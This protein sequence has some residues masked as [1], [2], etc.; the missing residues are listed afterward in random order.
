[1]KAKLYPLIVALFVVS[2]I[3]GLFMAIR[4]HDSNFEQMLEDISIQFNDPTVNSSLELVRQ[5]IDRSFPSD[6]FF[7][8]NLSPLT[9]YTPSSLHKNNLHQGQ[10]S[11]TGQAGSLQAGPDAPAIKTDRN[12]NGDPV[13]KLLG[14]PSWQSWLALPI[15]Y[16]AKVDPRLISELRGEVLPAH[17]G[18]TADES[19][20]APS[21]QRAL[22]KTR[23][24]VIL[25]EQVSLERE[26]AKQVYASSVEKRDAALDLLSAAARESQ[27]ALTSTLAERMNQGD[28]S[29]YH[30]FFI[31]N[32]MA[33]EGNLDTIIALSIRPDVQRIQASYPLVPLWTSGAPTRNSAQSNGAQTNTVQANSTQNT[34][35]S[36][37]VL[38]PGNW[39]IDLVNADEVW[40]RLG[41]RGEG[42][43]VAGFDTGVQYQHPAVE[44]NY[45]GRIGEDEYD[46][47]YN[48]FEPNGN[49]YPDGNLGA[50][51][52]EEPYD[53]DYYGTHGTHTM[54]TM[55][56]KEVIGAYYSA[57]DIGMAPRATW[58]ALPGICRGTMP[59]GISDDIGAMKAFQWLL[60]PTDLTGDLSTADC[61]KAP[62][63]VNNSWGSANPVNDVLHPAVEALRAAGIAPVFASG[64]P[65]AG[66]GSIG[67]PANSPAAI[68]VGATD[69]DDQIAYFSGR[70]PSFYSDEQKP[71]LSA[72]GVDVRS[73]VYSDYYSYYSGTSMAAPHVA[74]LV[75]LMI[76]ADLQDG[77][78]D[79]SVDD[80]EQFMIYSAVDLGAKGPDNDFGYGRID[81]YK[82]VS[83]VQSAGDLQGTITDAATGEPIS[84]AQ[85]VGTDST[86]TFQSQSGSTGVYSV[87]VPGG[88]YTIQIE[89]W[90]YEPATFDR[91]SVFARSISYADFQLTPKTATML[92]GV[93]QTGEAWGNL[94][95]SA[96]TPTTG[97]P[98][99]NAQIRVK[100]NPE[101][102]TTT[103]ADGSYSL[104]L[105]IGTHELQFQAENHH[106]L[107]STVEID[108]T[109][110][111]LDFTANV[112]PKLLLVAADAH[113]GWFSGWPVHPIFENALQTAGY[114]YDL[115]RIEYL[116]IDD[117]QISPDDG[118]TL[119]GIP[120]LATLQQYDVVM[121]VH[122]GCSN[123]YCSVGATPQSIEAEEL[124]ISYL[125]GGGRLILS[126]QNISAWTRSSSELMEY[127]GSKH[128]DGTGGTEG[129]ELMGQ[130]FLADLSVDITNA[131][132]YGYRNG[133][134]TLS[135]DVVEP[136]TDNTISAP[137]LE[138]ADAEGAAAL[139]ISPCN[140]NYRSVF[141]SVGYE[142]IGPRADNRDP[143]ATEIMDRS[144]QWLAEEKQEYGFAISPT[145]A[146]EAAS[147]AQTLLYQVSIVNTGRQP[148]NVG[149]SLA[150]TS[151][152]TR[153]YSGTTQADEMISD[154]SLLNLEEGLSMA[155]CTS[156]QMT[157]EVEIPE[158]IDN[159]DRDTAV[160]NFTLD[161]PVDDPAIEKSKAITLTTVAFAKWDTQANM[162]TSRYRLAVES[163]PDDIYIYTIGGW[164]NLNVTSSRTN[165]R[166][167]PCTNEW[168]KMASI[169]SS[170]TSA[171]S[172]QYNGEIYVTGGYRYSYYS[173]SSEAL[174][175]VHIYDPATDTW[176]LGPELG[177]PLYGHT[178]A[179]VGDK[180]YFFGGITADEEELDTV[181]E[182]DPES[183]DWLRKAP[184]PG[185]ERTYAKAV[186]Y[187]DKIY[188]IGGWPNVGSVDVYD[189]AINEWSK[190]ASLHFGRQSPGAA[191]APDG[192]IYVAG[193]GSGWDGTEIVERYHPELDEWEIISSL[194]DQNRAASGMAFA[195][196]RLFLMGGQSS[197]R[198][199]EAI[200]LDTSF[201]LSKKQAIVP[202]SQ[203]GGMLSYK[204]SIHSDTSTIPEAE[205]LDYLPIS[206]TFEGFNTN[207]IGAT[208]N[209]DTHQIEWSGQVPALGEPLVYSY[210]VA[211]DDADWAN[212][213]ILPSQI[214]FSD[215]PLDSAQPEGDGTIAPT[216]GQLFTRTVYS[217]I[218]IPDFAGSSLSASADSVVEGEMLT[219][220]VNVRS[221]NAAGGLVSITSTLPTGMDYVVGSLHA[222]NGQ[223]EYSR[224]DRTLRWTGNISPD[225]NAFL[226]NTDNYVWY[227]SNGENNIGPVPYTTGYEWIEISETGT[228]VTSGDDR[229]VCDQEIG[230]PFTFYDRTQTSFCVST[231]GF[232]SFDIYGYTSY[233]NDC[234]LPSRSSN[235]SLVAAMWND[236]IVENVYVQTI[237]SSPSRALVVQYQNAVPYYFGSSST[238][239]SDFQ[240]ILYETGEIKFQYKKIDSEKGGG[241]TIG[242][243]SFGGQRGSNYACNTSYSIDDNLA[244]TF[245]PPGGGLGNAQADVSFAVVV[246]EGLPVNSAI[247]NTVQIGDAMRQYTRTVSTELNPIGLEI[248]AE[249]IGATQVELGGRVDYQFML[250]NQGRFPAKDASL[251]FPIRKELTFVDD[252]LSCD[253]GTCTLG[254]N[255]IVTWN[256]VV[257]GES[258]VIVTFGA[259][260]TEKLNDNTRITSIATMSDGLG[261]MYE[262]R[263]DV[264]ARSSDLSRSISTLT[265][266]YSEKGQQQVFELIVRN[267]G[268]VQTESRA[269]IEIP[270]GL[271]IMEE[272]LLCGTGQCSIENGV[273]TWQGVSRPR[274]AIPIRIRVVVP[275]DSPYGEAFNFVV[276]ITDMNRQEGVEQLRTLTVARLAYFP[277]FHSQTPPTTL[278][279]PL[280]PFSGLLKR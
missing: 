240:L 61:S 155:P 31:V 119:S 151:W 250:K 156:A 36:L 196:G 78:R 84:T 68:T 143:A 15:E 141:F 76:S 53:C 2:S 213:S 174:T 25:K 44:P 82:A 198:T 98:I 197:V 23:F 194:N 277:L 195:A 162:P 244:I 140:A 11:V 216:S 19:L 257:A 99:A 177:T 215:A 30:S 233:Y 175:E 101:V 268:T 224:N 52:S 90:G 246:D 26:L 242:L 208:Y 173:Y 271:G 158:S 120:S 217:S 29:S 107:T 16:K 210:T 72:P 280:T 133:V 214:R 102:V 108:G 204:V 86:R 4:S 149:M 136:R 183:G 41:V 263:T 22:E 235:N 243:S 138:Y 239:T 83:W 69:I 33:A 203:P 43:V 206:T 8:E 142:N 100:G 218:F 123:Y 49:L 169:P 190:V 176:R 248:I 13:N 103:A 270:P 124:L 234:P 131:S 125:D 54:G 226:N 160:L 258:T 265:S 6:L 27:A 150:E 70:G 64:N 88:A 105:P 71:E 185:G 227:D 202:I 46:H 92:T 200:T 154:L 182:Y 127:M 58:I 135:P 245:T 261:N 178:I 159:G 12:S 251:V 85:V 272:S 259:R 75:A 220:T 232:I 47:N 55:A 189:P 77:I 21:D 114:P 14:S 144:I 256:G 91:Q 165:E 57:T 118:R 42:A 247:T 5:T 260:L 110:T 252:S 152:K 207:V 221:I 104:S 74:G 212:G 187:D 9:E 269:V 109:P 186:T 132:L 35:R 266:H 130:D 28:V 37:N 191:I 116:N 24:L 211:L 147:P 264:I 163:L 50:S 20:I 229:Y 188:L 222:P 112:A 96:A 181:Y 59:D 167:N 201:C 276:T 273:V 249:V 275:E 94:T 274:S 97:T 137:A 157:V 230:F 199:N 237:G 129:S 145:S 122:S 81:A 56:G 121:W 279:M 228:S 7:M 126:G 111:T 205:I 17:L 209:E 63:V 89:A 179:N 66:E 180:L 148:A 278:Y 236:L 192:Y 1:M 117:T 48:W 34:P 62:D 161:T 128:V 223:E 10:H 168:R 38:D 255:G 193:G 262:A 65:D 95:Q 51:L 60:C 134:L 113:G 80:I 238:D 18:G 93:A 79:F 146:Q 153:I 171:G 166:Y 115:W 87:T 225:Q 32:S 170:R 106:L 172:T 253:T 139:A 219:Y 254:A 231:N 164:D 67:T 184:I 40:T 73:S 39:N 3:V 45:R 267:S 241:S